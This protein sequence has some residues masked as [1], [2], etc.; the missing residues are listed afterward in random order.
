M[1]R[2]V[3]P[4]NT[5]IGCNKTKTDCDKDLINEKTDFTALSF[6]YITPEICYNYFENQ[7]KSRGNSNCN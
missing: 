4:D 1:S 7:V 6:L 3:K 2:Q 5:G